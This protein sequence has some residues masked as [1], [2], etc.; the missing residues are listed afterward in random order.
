M[1][2]PL[3]DLAG[4]TALVTGS[5]R[6]LGRAMAED[7]AKAGARILVNGTDAARADDH[8]RLAKRGGAHDAATPA[9]RPNEPSSA[10]AACCIASIIT[11]AS[12]W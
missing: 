8:H 10:G 2:N 9:M 11:P 4:R 12:S 5:S 6:G 7:L 3:F 1:T